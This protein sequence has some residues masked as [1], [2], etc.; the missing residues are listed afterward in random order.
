MKTSEIELLKME[1]EFEDVLEPIHFS[2]SS[3]RISII[4]DGWTDA[5]NRPLIKIIV[6][7]FYIIFQPVAALLLLIIPSYIYVRITDHIYM[8]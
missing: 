3:S 5:R 2:W 8:W 1:K 7:T 6:R 4:S